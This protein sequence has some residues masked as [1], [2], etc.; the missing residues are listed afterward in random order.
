[1]VYAEVA[2]PLPTPIWMD[3][4][5]N[6]CQESNA[7]GCQVTHR[8]CH[9]ELCFV[10]DEVGGNISMKGDG[11]VGGQ[12][13]CTE[14]GTIPYR[15]ASHT[16]KKFTMIGLT[17]LDGNPVM[18]VLIIQGKYPDLSV[19]T[20]IDV[21]IN[22]DRNTEDVDFFFNNNGEG[23]YFPGGPVCTYRGK[24]IPTMIRWNKSASITSDILV[25]MLKTL[26]FLDVIPRDG[27]RI[28]FLLIDGHGSRLELPFLNYINTPTDHWVVCIG[29]PYGTALWQVG[30]SK[31]QNGS[32]N[33]A[34][35]KA[36]QELLEFKTRH[37][38]ENPTLQPTD[39]IPLINKAWK[40]SFARVDKNRNAIS[41]RGWNPL[42]RNL[43]LDPL[44]RQTMTEKEKAME[45]TSN[46]YKV[47]SL[48]LNNNH[49]ESENVPSDSSTS[50]TSSTHILSAQTSL[51]F[52]SGTSLF[53]LTSIVKKEQLM[54]ARER[55]KMDQKEGDDAVEKLK[56]SKK[57]TAGICYKND[58]VHLGK[59]VFEVCREKI[60][61]KNNE[62]REK[63]QKQERT[64]LELKRKAD[65]LIASKANIELLSN[66]DLNVILRSL[67]RK[68]DKNKLPT[69]KQMMIELYYQ[70]KDRE[71]KKIDYSAG[72][73]GNVT[74][75]DEEE[76]V[77]VND[78]EIVEI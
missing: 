67:K 3:N 33:M 35:S 17:S 50:S 25:D 27:K 45:S 40:Q 32:F 22:P 62:L 13:L 31:E 49:I 43:L 30:D 37:T 12:K 1:M 77:V 6:K 39:L 20:R 46:D 75:V 9:P 4:D 57:L 51:N 76:D 63:I 55:I 7:L 66:K 18:C 69:K 59:S 10:G 28:P 26:D 56:K 70:W 54:Q 29:V 47:P 21:T 48:V 41:S 61:N 19:E 71:P 73:N 60:Q 16:E 23:K 74:T 52:S 38:F 42:N 8:L 24:K 64:Y 65:E 34:M 58:V 2:E 78:D 11:H 53:C 44:I 14:Q 15:K 36:K 68:E 72:F 5:G